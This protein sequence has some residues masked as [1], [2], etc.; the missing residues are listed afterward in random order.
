MKT[1]RRFKPQDVLILEGLLGAVMAIMDKVDTHREGIQDD[2][3]WYD[4]DSI[5][6]GIADVS[7]RC[8]A[9]KEKFIGEAK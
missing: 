7:E 6:A 2:Q 1:K 3:L 4:L 8:I 5:K 9:M